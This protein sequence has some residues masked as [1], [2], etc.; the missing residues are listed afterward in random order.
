MISQSDILKI[1]KRYSDRYELNGYSPKTLGWSSKEQQELRFERFSKIIDLNKK[2][3]LD[4]G[5]GF[6]DFYKYLEVKTDYEFNYTGIDINPDLIKEA[7]KN[8]KGENVKFLQINILEEFENKFLQK[9]KFH[10]VLAMGVFNLNFVDD[11]ILM[12]KFLIE[13]INKMISISS[14]KV[15]F[16]FLPKFRLDTYKSENYIMEYSL[17]LIANIMSENKLK[18]TIFCDQD[19]NPMSEALVLV[20]K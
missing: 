8:I 9:Q 18:Y 3:I 12:Q 16:D 6:G 19:P 20:E 7:K 17:D 2:N 10:I 4:I 11:P 1:N 15:L 5:C 13:M 14:G